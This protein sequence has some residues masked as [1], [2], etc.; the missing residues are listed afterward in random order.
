MVVH[1]RN[2]Q[3][4]II[5]KNAIFLYKYMLNRN[6]F[7]SR[8]KHASYTSVSKDGLTINSGRAK[9]DGDGFDLEVLLEKHIV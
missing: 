5:V 9:P 7:A 8:S 2:E 6:H 4:E 3:C 1:P